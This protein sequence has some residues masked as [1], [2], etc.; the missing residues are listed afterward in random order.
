LTVHRT[1]I[2]ALLLLVA[3]CA[4]PIGAERPVCAADWLDAEVEIAHG[5]GV[6]EEVLPIECFEQIDS[7]RL[8]I[9]FTIPPGPACHVLHSIGLVESADAVAITLT[10][11]VYDDPNAGACPEVARQAATELDLQ[12]PLGDRIVLDGSG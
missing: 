4:A 2:A 12:A 9:G 8:R 6:R 3:G 10:G 7:R 1:L 11:A 5:I